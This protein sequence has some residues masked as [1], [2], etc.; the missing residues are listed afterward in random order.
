MKHLETEQRTSK[1]SSTYYVRVKHP[2]YFANI[3]KS[4]IWNNFL[5]MVTEKCSAT[6]HKGALAIHVVS[7]IATIVC[8]LN[9][10]CAIFYPMEQKHNIFI[11]Y[12]IP[13]HWSDTG[14]WNLSSSKTITY[15]FYL[16]NTMCVGFLATWA[17]VTATMILTMLNRINSVPAR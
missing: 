15:L 16:A 6:L 11:F 7:I 5:G 1:S 4:E 17:R 14:C 12:V 13:P 10:V 3:T 8:L 2:K 9:P